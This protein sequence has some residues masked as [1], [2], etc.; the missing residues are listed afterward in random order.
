MLFV[1][2]R[3]YFYFVAGA[4]I[5]WQDL[6]HCN[7]NTYALLVDSKWF[8]LEVNAE[9]TVVCVHISSAECRSKSQHEDL[10]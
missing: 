8:G 5:I 2:F 3:S 1:D 6:K 4:E 9:E 7:E 10:W